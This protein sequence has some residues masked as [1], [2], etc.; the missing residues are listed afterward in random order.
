MINKRKLL[1]YILNSS[2]FVTIGCGPTIRQHQSVHKSSGSRSQKGSIT[3]M[4]SDCNYPVPV[5][6]EVQ[7]DGRNRMNAPILEDRISPV[8]EFNHIRGQDVNLIVYPKCELAIVGNEQFEC[9]KIKMK[10]EKSFTYPLNK[11]NLFIRLDTNFNYKDLPKGEFCENLDEEYFIKLSE[12]HGYRT[13]SFLKV[14]KNSNNLRIKQISFLTA[15]IMSLIIGGVE[16]WR[17]INHDLPD[18]PKEDKDAILFEIDEY[19]RFEDSKQDKYNK[20]ARAWSFSTIGLSFI[21]FSFVLDFID[22]DLRAITAE[23]N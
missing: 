22:D 17:A 21:L 18:I 4:S 11:K 1:Y 20:Q 7:R 12:L 10:I 15:G 13:M 14:N 5:L 19:R 3:F 9:D 23:E 6:L 2:F 16:S 8:F